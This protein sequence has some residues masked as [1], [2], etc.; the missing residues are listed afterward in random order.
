VYDWIVVM[1]LTPKVIQNFGKNAQLFPKT[2]FLVSM[3]HV[4]LTTT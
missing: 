4:L 2:F 3:Q 1:E